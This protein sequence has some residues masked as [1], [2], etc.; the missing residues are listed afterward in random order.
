MI[1]PIRDGAMHKIRKAGWV[2]GIVVMF[3]GCAF[4]EDAPIKPVIISAEVEDDSDDPAIWVHP[5]DPSQSLILGTDKGGELLAFDLSGKV[6][7][8]QEKLLRPNNVDVEYGVMLNGQR[9]DI[10]VVTDRDAEKIFIFRMPDLASLDGGEGIDVFEG[11]EESDVMGVGLYKRPDDGAVF[12]IL[13][14]KSGSKSGYLWQY[15]VVDRGDRLGIEKVR[16]F[17]RWSGMAE[18]EAVVVDDEL[19]FVYY[20]DE[21]FGIRKYLADPDAPNAESELMVFGTD[22]FVEDREGVSIYTQPNGQGYI[23]V[24]DQQGNAFHIFQRSGDHAKVGV[25]TLST[26]NSDGSDVT[27]VRLNAQFPDGLFVAMSNDRTFHFY[28]WREIAKK[29]ERQ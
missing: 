11:E 24:S 6:V 3:L 20:S 4:L 8:K 10:A 22:G 19:G 28:D 13:S 18:I 29:I 17:G 9:V 2:V 25:I 21:V 7:A 15:R 16:A 23:L 26:Q 27:S 14:R 5:D 1:D 12:V